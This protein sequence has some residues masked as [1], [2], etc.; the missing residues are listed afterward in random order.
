MSLQSFQPAIKRVKKNGQDVIAENDGTLIS[1][2]GA[3]H[4]RTRTCGKYSD[5]VGI[6]LSRRLVWFED[7]NERYAVQYVGSSLTG[8]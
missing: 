8:K 6:N 2:K 7:T 5:V 1:I 4:A 3:V